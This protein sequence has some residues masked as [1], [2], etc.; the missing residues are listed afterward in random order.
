MSHLF[1]NSYTNEIGYL[2]GL[3]PVKPETREAYDVVETFD[4]REGMAKKSSKIPVG[5]MG[6]S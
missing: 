1:I 6:P 2:G 5:G 4:K 3:S